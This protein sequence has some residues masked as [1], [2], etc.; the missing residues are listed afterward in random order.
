M[1]TVALKRNLPTFFGFIEKRRKLRQKRL[2]KHLQ[3]LPLW[4]VWFQVALNF[5]LIGTNLTL[6]WNKDEYL[7]D[8]GP[9]IPMIV[10]LLFLFYAVISAFQLRSQFFK[11]RGARLV[12]IDIALTVLSFLTWTG[13]IVAFLP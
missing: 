12:K 6:I 1:N 5:L 7:T 9:S 2:P 8:V 13:A 4:P 3:P 10:G 11:G